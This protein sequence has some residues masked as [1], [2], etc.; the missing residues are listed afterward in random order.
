MPDPENEQQAAE[1]R[2]EVSQD[3]AQMLADARAEASARPP[4]ELPGV[5]AERSRTTQEA[6]LPHGW[7]Y[8]IHG[9]DSVRWDLTQEAVTITKNGLSCITSEDA[10]RDAYDTTASYAAPRTPGARQVEVRIPFLREELSTRRGAGDDLKS[11]K[12][13]L[14]PEIL[15]LVTKYHQ[16]RHARV[17]RHETLIKIG[18]AQSEG[19]R[20]IEYMVPASVMDLYRESV[21]RQFD[22]EIT[23]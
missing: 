12:A 13:S 21:K 18:E 3:Y 6:P 20:I 22:Q 4:A 16:D 2:S 8:L 7:T 23:N 17:P 11:L 15:A 10:A 9:T 19:G 1:G 14:D 5:G